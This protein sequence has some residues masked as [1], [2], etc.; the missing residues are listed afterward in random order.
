MDAIFDC[1]LWYFPLLAFFE[2]ILINKKRIF[3]SKNG[4]LRAPYDEDNSYDYRAGFLFALIVFLPMLLIAGFRY[5]YF[6]DTTSYVNTFTNFYPNSISEL[7]TYLTGEERAPGFIIFGVL[8]KQIFGN[9]FRIY[10]LIIA[11]I[12]TLSLLSTYRKYTSEIVFVAFLFFSSSD[13][14]SW[15]MNGMRQFLVASIFFAIVP[16][17][18]NKKFIPFL[19]IS[20][21]LIS[22]HTS[23]LI[24]IPVFI[25]ALGKPMN[26]R[27][28]LM[29]GGILLAIIFID[30][31]SDLLNDT[32]QNTN[33]QASASEI[34]DRESDD[35]T[36][37]LRA[38]FYSIPAIL[39]LFFRKKIPSDAP[40]IINY[41]VNMSLMTM[42]FYFLSVAM[43]GIYLGRIP[44]YFSLFNYILL[45]WEIKTFFDKDTR[46]IVFVI[47]II[48]YIIFYLYQMYTWGLV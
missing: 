4:Q 18:L 14:M 3:A 5:R 20:L 2:Y 16:L 47:V 42:A 24:A 45:P 30:Q 12:S 31:F 6:A 28:F 35:G 19:I 34:T 33:Y 38:L 37:I 7:S 9:N 46:K 44:I 13:M 41:S 25:L 15:M 17:L 27:T 32:L 29:M 10:L 36:N 40:Q 39:A 11:S 43:S 48:V 21:I 22:F 26:K 1:Y 8:I 23:A